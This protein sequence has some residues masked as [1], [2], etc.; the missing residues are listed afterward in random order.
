MESVRHINRLRDADIAAHDVVCGDGDAVRGDT[1]VS[2][3]RGPLSQRVNAGVGAAGT[4][5]LDLLACDPAQSF[6]QNALGR[7]QSRLALPPVEPGPVIF[8]GQK[9]VAVQARG[10][11]GGMILRFSCSRACR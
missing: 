10:L 7:P 1:K 5:H 8:Y 4:V 9:N 6:F 3:E 2:L 11:R